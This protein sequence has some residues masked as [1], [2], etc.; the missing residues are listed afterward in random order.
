MGASYKV[1][2]EGYAPYDIAIKID[3]DIPDFQEE[4]A[5]IS[6]QVDITDYVDYKLYESEEIPDLP[7]LA[8]LGNSSHL[9]RWT[10]GKASILSI[11]RKYIKGK[12]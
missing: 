2:I 5:Y 8:I 7:V 4:L 12:P 10:S 6:D 11:V 9:R 1:N 3:A